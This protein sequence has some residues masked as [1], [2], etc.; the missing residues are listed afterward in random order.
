[1]TQLNNMA[2]KAGITYPEQIFFKFLRKDGTAQWGNVGWKLPTDHAVGD[3]MTETA[4]EH[5]YWFGDAS[6]LTT[7][8]HKRL[9]IAQVPNARTKDIDYVGTRCK[10]L[11][12]IKVWKEDPTILLHLVCDS[13]DHVLHIPQLRDPIRESVRLLKST[14][15]SAF[16][17]FDV[18]GQINVP[19]YH[20]LS[21]PE[22]CII[23]A[24]EATILAAKERLAGESFWRKTC[25]RAIS[26][27]SY[28]LSE[29]PR[30]PI[31][32]ENQAVRSEWEWQTDRLVSYFSDELNAK[33]RWVA[34]L[35]S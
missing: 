17:D 27:A 32:Q 2:K 21:E 6:G 24:V 10:L 9:F 7:W 13:I 18:L 14:L 22:S 15:R 34:G 5:P 31:G 11:F 30:P 33:L 20:D 4:H 23:E 19:K 16:E 3:W 1:M 29:H 26:A 28:V 12:E 35:E 8:I 25:S